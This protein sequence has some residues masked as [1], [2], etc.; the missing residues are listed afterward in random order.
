MRRA[1]CFPIDQSAV[2]FRKGHTEITTDLAHLASLYAEAALIPVSTRVT[3]FLRLSCK[4]IE[5]YASAIPLSD[6]V[7]SKNSTEKKARKPKATFISSEKQTVKVS[8]DVYPYSSD[9]DDNDNVS[10]KALDSFISENTQSKLEYRIIPESLKGAIPDTFIWPPVC[11]G[12]RRIDA[13][14]EFIN[15][16][17]AVTVPII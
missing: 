2:D 7:T 4:E 6:A 13:Q 5:R 8:L 17:E 15:P 11:I 14:P 9:D 12:P 3:Q 10:E 16:D 1:L